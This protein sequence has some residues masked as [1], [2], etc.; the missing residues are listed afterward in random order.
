M[1]KNLAC[2]FAFCPIIFF[3]GCDAQTVDLKSKFIP[4]SFYNNVIRIDDKDLTKN[5]ASSL[6]DLALPEIIKDSATFFLE[7]D[8]SPE[9]IA[10]SNTFYPELNSFVLIV[11]DREYYRQVNERARQ[12]NGCILPIETNFY[13][14]V[15]RSNDGVQI[16]SV[17]LMGSENVNWE[18]ADL[19]EPEN[20]IKVYHIDMFGSKCCPR[21]MKWDTKKDF[22]SY[23]DSVH[24]NNGNTF[25]VPAGEEGA[26]WIYFTFSNL[27][28]ENIIQALDIRQRY[29][30]S[31]RND[32]KVNT[33]MNVYTPILVDKKML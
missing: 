6:I 17:K 20:A 9:K 19:T 16:D 4:D 21:D 29:Y 33:T 12:I 1:L 27:S 14:K 25:T 22:R 31:E 23:I 24:K 7:A 5:G 32:K 10:H 28:K 2:L 26:H 11:P 18:P 8:I 30:P 13:F 3:T 15:V